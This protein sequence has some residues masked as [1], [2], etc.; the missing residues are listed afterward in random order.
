MKT[1]LH[2]WK[3]IVLTAIILYL[4]FAPPSTFNGVPTFMYEDKVIHILLYFGLSVILIFDNWN[5]KRN[6]I[7]RIHFLLCCICFP[8]LLGGLIEILQPMYFS[9][10]TAEWSDWFSDIAGVAV[11]FFVMNLLKFIPKSVSDKSK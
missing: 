1:L 6:N 10:R 4:S 8:I 7:K 11:G 9:P 3:S 2:Y 5:Y